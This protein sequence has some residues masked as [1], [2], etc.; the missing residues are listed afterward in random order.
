M[1]SAIRIESTTR[2][3]I[4]FLS[5]LLAALLT[6][7]GTALAFDI[8]THIAESASEASTF[9]KNASLRDMRACLCGPQR[10]VVIERPD[11]LRISASLYET[12]DASEFP[13]VLLIHGNIPDGRNFHVYKVLASKLADRG[14][15]V[16]TIDIPGYG[17]SDD[18]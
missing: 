17:E 2:K 1:L 16:L 8:P 14:Y 9:I 7:I 4:V 3:K 18:P 5:V 15:R 13:A 6:S 12:H 11:G 10:N